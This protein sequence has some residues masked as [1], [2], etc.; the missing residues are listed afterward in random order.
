MP[1]AHHST[2]IEVFRLRAGNTLVMVKLCTKARRRTRR[3]DESRNYMLPHVC[4][5]F[6]GCKLC[7]SIPTEKSHRRMSTVHTHTLTHTQTANTKPENPKPKKD[8]ARKG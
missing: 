6:S 1:R 2:N 3:E 4:D 7:K 5:K 8:K